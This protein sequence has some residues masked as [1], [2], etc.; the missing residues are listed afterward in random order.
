MNL[1][2]LRAPILL[3]TVLLALAG[4]CKTTP[5]DTDQSKPAT[6]A[7]AQKPKPKKPVT[8]MRDMRGDVTFQAFVGRLRAAVAAKDIHEI[9]GMMT[10]NFGYHLNPDLEGEGVFAYWDQN[11]VWPELQLVIRESFVPFGDM[12]DGFMVAPPEFASANQYTGYR[13]GI[14]L[15]N[16]SWKFAYFVNGSGE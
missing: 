8:T 4:G 9:A 15:V 7:A 5:E 16:G 6:T 10:T 11:N 3:T 13:A 2:L 12:R 14:Q 1:R